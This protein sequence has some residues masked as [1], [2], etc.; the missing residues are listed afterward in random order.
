MGHL[1][2]PIAFR[3][4]INKSWENTWY[5]K[6]LYY[7]EYLHNILNLKKFCILYFY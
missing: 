5:I 6:N 1:I 4:G 2:N 7:A 3:L